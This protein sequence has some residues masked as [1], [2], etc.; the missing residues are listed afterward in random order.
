MNFFRVFNGFSRMLSD[1]R[2]FNE[3]QQLVLENEEKA[4]PT[5]FSCAGGHRD[6]VQ[7]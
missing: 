7:P 3:P 4:F 2:D 5:A 1:F 6:T